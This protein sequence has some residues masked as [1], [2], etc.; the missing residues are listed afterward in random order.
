VSRDQEQGQ[1]LDTQ[2]R[3]QDLGIRS[4]GQHQ[5]FRNSVMHLIIRANYKFLHDDDDDYEEAG[6]ECSRVLRPSSGDHKT[7]KYSL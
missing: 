6:I 5:D 7:G 2:S 3:G 4:R 1:D